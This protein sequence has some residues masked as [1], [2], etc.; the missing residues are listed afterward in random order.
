MRNW[1]PSSSILLSIFDQNSFDRT[2]EE[3]KPLVVGI[4]KPDSR[5]CFDRTYEELKLGNATRPNTAAIRGF[6]RTYEEL[7]LPH[8]LILFCRNQVLIVPMRN[9]NDDRLLQRDL[10]KRVLIVPM[11][12]WNL[13]AANPYSSLSGASFD[14]TYEEL[15][16]QKKH[17]SAIL[18]KHRFDR[19][20]EELKLK[21]YFF[22]ANQSFL[23]FDR[24]YEELKRLFLGLLGNE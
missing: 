11:R 16:L 23:C 10:R 20:Y 5:D 7:K 24:T 9:W 22:I 21:M 4:F 18:P 12:N 17:I 6:D 3:L 2:Y 15:K 19:T 8:V 14:R 13:E 1:N